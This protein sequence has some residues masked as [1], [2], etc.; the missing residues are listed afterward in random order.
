MYIFPNSSRYLPTHIF[1]YLWIFPIPW[2]ILTQGEI[3]PMEKFS[4]GGKLSRETKREILAK[5]GKE[6]FRLFCP[7]KNGH[8]ALNVWFGIDYLA[9]YIFCVFFFGFSYFGIYYHA[10]NH[11]NSYLHT[12]KPLKK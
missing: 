1:L 2:E 8:L 3:E 12:M 7:Y 11:D 9:H 4:K 6:S 5:G 10:K